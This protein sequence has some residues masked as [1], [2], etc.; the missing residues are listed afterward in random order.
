MTV[1]RNPRWE[2][3]LKA[4]SPDGAD[5]V[6]PP[7]LP[8][9]HTWFAWAVQDFQQ[10]VELFKAT[11]ENALSWGWF[12]RTGEDTEGEKPAVDVPR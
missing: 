9:D 1:P 11:W 8:L 5:L 3:A 7:P 2:A 6:H 10:Q 4:E 12:P